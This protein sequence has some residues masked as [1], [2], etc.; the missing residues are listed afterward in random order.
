LRSAQVRSFAAARLRMTQ[1]S[2]QVLGVR[3]GVLGVGCE[4]FNMHCCIT[5]PGFS[6]GYAMGDAASRTIA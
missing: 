6:P 2:A 3:F 1:R 5:A 4:M